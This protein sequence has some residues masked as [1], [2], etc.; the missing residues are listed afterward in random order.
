MPFMVDL[1]QRQQRRRNSRRLASQHAELQVV[2]VH[3]TVAGLQLRKGLLRLV[4]IQG[5]RA[6]RGL[7]GFACF[8]LC[9]LRLRLAH[10]PAQ[11]SGLPLVIR[12]LCCLLLVVFIVKHRRLARQLALQS[13]Q[14]LVV[15]GSHLPR[16]L[17]LLSDALPLV[18]RCHLLALVL[19]EHLVTEHLPLSQPLF[20]ALLTVRRMGKGL[21]RRG[22]DTLGVSGV[23]RLPDVQT[24][25]KSSLRVVQQIS[26]GTHSAK[27]V[28]AC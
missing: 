17:L 1:P 11:G 14:S 28:E 4:Q 10:H 24:L 15:F 13:A 18:F 3:L 19:V 27:L 26:I 25:A 12:G 23:D 8:F 22:R 9:C 2:H 5:F 6:L 16:L 20:D 21:Q 7:G